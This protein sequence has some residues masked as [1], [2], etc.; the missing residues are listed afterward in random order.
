[1]KSKPSEVILVTVHLLSVEIDFELSGHIR[2]TEVGF[3][4]GGLV[5]ETVEGY[6]A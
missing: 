4:V 2:G 6:I 1:M 5:N 3:P